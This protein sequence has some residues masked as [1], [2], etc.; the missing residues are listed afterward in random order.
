[1]R[2]FVAVELPP[3]VVIAADTVARELRERIAQIAPRARLTWVA[4]ERMHVTV[5]FI[6]EVNDET[7]T[8]IRG[9]LAPALDSPPLAFVLGDVG[10]FPTRGAPRALW[11]GL[12]SASEAVAALETEV[13]R[14]LAQ[15]G[16]PPESRPF[17]PHVTLA[18]VREAA[19]LRASALL[20]DVA[21]PAARGRIDAITLFASRLSPRGSTYTALQRTGLRR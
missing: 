9:V 15:A 8:A 11:L 18:R 4:P 7:A 19:G 5:R 14:R 6:G 1:M 3:P 13:S 21:P 20:A 17:T 16:V 10:A 12:R 2:L